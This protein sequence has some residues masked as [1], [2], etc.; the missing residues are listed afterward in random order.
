MWKR[1]FKSAQVYRQHKAGGLHIVIEITQNASLRLICHTPYEQCLD[2]WQH[3]YRQHI[4]TVDSFSP[5]CDIMFPKGVGSLGA[6]RDS[7]VLGVPGILEASESR[8]S[9]SLRTMNCTIA[10]GSVMLQFNQNIL[11][12]ISKH[13]RDLERMISKLLL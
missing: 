1:N 11:A 8:E 13:V 4:P 3:Q 5:V 2:Q 9:R 12:H 10:V 6:S 7:E